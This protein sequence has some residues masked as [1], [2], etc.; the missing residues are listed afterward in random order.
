MCQGRNNA[1]TIPF[2]SK[3]TR[4]CRFAFLLAF[5]RNGTVLPGHAY[6]LTPLPM[7]KAQFLSTLAKL[8]KGYPLHSQDCEED[9]RFIAKLFD[10]A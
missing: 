1:L 3:R 4:I 9:P 7:K 2:L 8:T 6:F 5:S 10:I